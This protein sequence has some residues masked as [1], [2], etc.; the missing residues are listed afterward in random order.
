MAW[1]IY[2]LA[3]LMWLTT[4]AFSCARGGNVTSRKLRRS[5]HTLPDSQ[6][7]KPLAVSNINARILTVAVSCG[8]SIIGLLL[9]AGEDVFQLNSSHAAQTDRAVAAERLR[10]QRALTGALNEKLDRRLPVM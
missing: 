4:A 6:D 3:V 8:L 2:T 10:R 1:L 9:G 5:C 7:E